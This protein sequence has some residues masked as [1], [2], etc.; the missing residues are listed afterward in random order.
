MSIGAR[1]V[2]A[3]FAPKGG[4]L[5]FLIYGEVSFMPPFG[6]VMGEACTRNRLHAPGVWL[7]TL[8]TNGEPSET[9]THLLRLY[10]AVRVS[11]AAS[12]SVPMDGMLRLGMDLQE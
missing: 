3:G 1:I 8:G 4:P 2:Q 6:R 7:T 10:E 5:P 12:R 11:S 9:V